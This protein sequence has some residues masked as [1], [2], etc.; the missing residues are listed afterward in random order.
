MMIIGVD[1]HPA[2]R[3]LHFLWKR[4]VSVVNKHSDGEAERF[5]PS[6]Q[7]RNSRA[8]GMEHGYSRWFRATAGRVGVR[9]MDGQSRGIKAKQ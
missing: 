7:R 8:V 9:G 6:L 2:F 1:Y 3:R 5:Y 4:P